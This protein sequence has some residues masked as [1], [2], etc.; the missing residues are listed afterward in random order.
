M[1]LLRLPKNRQVH[2]GRIGV[3]SGGR[4]HGLGCWQGAASSRPCGRVV[5]DS[6]EFERFGC[7]GVRAIEEIVGPICPRG[8]LV[9]LW[10]EISDDQEEPRLY[11]I[12]TR[13]AQWER[14]VDAIF[15]GHEREGEDGMSLVHLVYDGEDC[16]REDAEVVSLPEASCD[17]LHRAVIASCSAFQDAALGKLLLGAGPD[18]GAR[19]VVV[20]RGRVAKIDSDCVEQLGWLSGPESIVG[21]RRYG[22]A[23]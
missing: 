13:R 22:Q 7:D 10:E 8:V 18:V 9:A 20:L 21:V 5:G 23:L 1:I 6:I 17:R 16:L 19:V 2:A 4:P 12:S 14:A 15:P 11:S 3:G